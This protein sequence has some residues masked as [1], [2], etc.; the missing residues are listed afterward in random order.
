MSQFNLDELL[1]DKTTRIPLNEIVE[2]YAP[3][4]FEEWCEALRQ[5]L[6]VSIENS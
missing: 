1:S 4:T 6:T 5:A 2:E 3:K